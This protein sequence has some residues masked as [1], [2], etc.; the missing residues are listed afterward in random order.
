MFPLSTVLY[1]HAQI[2]LHIFEPRYRAMVEECL[3][4]DARF[5]VVLIARGS[6]VGGGDQRMMVGTRAVIT[7]AASLPDGR[8]VLVA[9]GDARIRVTEWL[10]DDPYPVAHIE[11]WAPEVEAVEAALVAQALHCVRRTRGLLAEH[12]SA[13]ALSA[14]VV[15]SE[16][17]DVASWQLCGEMPLSMMDAQGLLSAA[18]T[19]QRLELLIEFT[20]AIEDD[21]RRLM[22]AD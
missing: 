21:L 11:E 16:D 12:G 20:E 8:W 5:G 22:A 14:D 18:G 9:Q 4:G 10:P 17:C 6:E 2:P 1:P 3:A 7:K 15:F 19:R 13:A